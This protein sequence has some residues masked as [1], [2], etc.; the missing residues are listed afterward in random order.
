MTTDILTASYHRAGGEYDLVS[1]SLSLSP[2]LSRPL[3]SSLAHSSRLIST[4]RILPI[5]PC[6][7]R[8]ASPAPSTSTTIRVRTRAPAK[9]K[10]TSC[11]NSKHPTSCSPLSPANPKTLN[12]PTPRRKSP[13]SRKDSVRTPTPILLMEH[14]TSWTT[15]KR[16]FLPPSS[17]TIRSR[18]AHF[19]TA[20]SSA[21]SS[22][23]HERK[24]MLANPRVLCISASSK[25]YGSTAIS[26]RVCDSSK[27]NASLSSTIATAWSPT[28]RTC[29]GQCMRCARTHT[30]V[31][32]VQV[33]AQPT[34]PPM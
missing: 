25:S 21:P 20:C 34:V 32:D 8:T 29:I 27:R 15:R 23:K 24:L 30:A 11:V 7:A 1:C 14:A 26:V 18:S 19:S 6:L 5:Q 17:A 3:L 22:S 33:R 9:S 12:T 13:A 28:T 16:L 31:S 10:S 4:L 2:L